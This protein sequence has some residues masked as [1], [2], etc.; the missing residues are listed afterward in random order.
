MWIPK[1]AAEVEE[2]AAR[3]DLEE[4]HTFDAKSALPAAKKN[5]DL[6]VDVDAMT[7]DGGPLLYGLGEDEDGRLTVLAPVE[8]AGTPERVAQIVETS[9]S[10]PPFIRIQTL[11]LEED[12]SKG[13]VL[14]IVSRSPRAPH[15]VISA[16]DM[17]YYGL[18]AKG[19]RVLSEA[20]VAAALRAPRSPRSGSPSAACVVVA[21]RSQYRRLHRVA[22]PQRFR[23]ERLA[24]Q[25]LVIDRHAQ[26]RR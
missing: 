6:A 14:V 2:A 20:E 1:T 4:T 5:R 17:R 22:P 8:L 19:N 26:E 3:G 25:A 24:G 12:T 16:G 7:V 11:P 18:G 10:E 13:Y 9:I 15:Q 21:D 23:F